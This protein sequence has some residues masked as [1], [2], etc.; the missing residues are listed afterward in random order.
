MNSIC[1]DED[2][3]REIRLRLSDISWWMRLL[4]Q[5]I[6]IRANAEDKKTGRFWEG[7]FKSV[8]LLDEEAI[9]ACAVYVDLNPIRAAMA[10]T[11]EQSKFTSAQRRVESLKQRQTHEPKSSKGTRISL[12][13]AFLA[14][15]QYS[16][17]PGPLPSH[18]SGRCSDKGFT[19]LT[20]A[21]YLQLLDWS[22]REVIDGKIGSTP[23]DTPAFLD[24]L[25]L[26]LATWC[27]LISNFGTL[28]SLIAGQPHR[29]DEYRTNIRKQRFNMKSAARQLLS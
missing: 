8:R 26:N 7:R 10:E 17:S 20:E 27:T 2:R 16:S 23:K 29:I 15:V 1:S 21:D 18:Q 3:L 13:D 5:R 25:N 11:I 9:L 12:R 19:T 24:R 6:S 4:C 14:P 22:A 28:F